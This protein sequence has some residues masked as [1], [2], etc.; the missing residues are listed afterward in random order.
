VFLTGIP[1]AFLDAFAFR[2]VV[3]EGLSVRDSIARAVTVLREGAGPI[4]ILSLG[5]FVVG[6]AL[7]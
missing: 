4:L 3:L 7:S 2:A 5:C 6:L 1:V